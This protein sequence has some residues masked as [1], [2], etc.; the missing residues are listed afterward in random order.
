LNPNIERL[1][2]YPFERLANLKK[3]L[4]PADRP[5]I[6][7]SIGEPRHAPA[8]FLVELLRDQ[9]TLRAGL[10]SYP[11]TRGSDA[12]RTTIADWLTSRF[13]L[14]RDSL[15]PS[16]HVL[17]V[18]GTREALFSFGQAMLSGSP[19]AGVLMP[20]PCYQIYE[21]AAL[22][23]NAQPIYV[24]C[25][26]DAGFNPDFQGVAEDVWQCCELVYIC[27]P[28]NPTGAILDV[29]SLTALIELAD[30]HEFVIAADECY[31]EIYQDEAHPPPGLLEACASIGRDDYRRC[32]VFHSL[33]KRSNL[34][35]LR[36]GFVAGDAELMEAYYRYRTYHGGAMPDHVQVVSAAAWADENHVVANRANYREKFDAIT[37]MLSRHLEVNIPAGGFYYWTSTPEPDPDF[38]RALFEA[39]N[40]TVLP[41]SF[42]ARERNG[43]NPGANR[44]RMALVASLDECRD[45]ASRI[46]EFMDARFGAR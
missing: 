35:G 45:A 1:N 21:G 3:G 40:V 37:P 5:P 31:S 12:L 9:D 39:Q 41:G 29:S 10:S 27:S 30:R 14:T 20:N 32:I 8:D 19:T 44:V 26:E 36:S 23:R 25:P 4:V 6:A 16:R 13:S 11:A 38:A 34:P 24:P 33:S 42:L 22:L 17:P 43:V 46:I 2:S 28:G 15:D 18:N 7:L